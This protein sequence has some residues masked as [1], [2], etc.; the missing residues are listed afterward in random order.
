MIIIA[1][2]TYNGSYVS[3]HV[4]LYFIA[5]REYVTDIYIFTQKEMAPTKAAGTAA[6]S[7]KQA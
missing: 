5:R 3:V 6:A 7:T 2:I 4:I 1:M